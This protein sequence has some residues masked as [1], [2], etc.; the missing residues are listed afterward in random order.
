MFKFLRKFKKPI[1]VAALDRV[2]ISDLTKLDCRVSFKGE[3]VDLT[4]YNVTDIVADR[5]RALLDG[6]T[7]VKLSVEPVNDVILDAGRVLHPGENILYVTASDFNKEVADYVTE[8]KLYG[9]GYWCDGDIYHPSKNAVGSK[10]AITRSINTIREDQ[11]M[12]SVACDIA[13]MADKHSKSFEELKKLIAKYQY[14]VPVV[15]HIRVNHGC[16][17]S[18]GDFFITPELV[19]GYM[20]AVR[21]VLDNESFGRLREKVIEKFRIASNGNPEAVDYNK[22][23]VA[24]PAPESWQH[25]YYNSIKPE[26]ERRE[27]NRDIIEEIRGTIAEH[28]RMTELGHKRLVQR[29]SSLLDG[30]LAK[31]FPEDVKHITQG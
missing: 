28:E 10:L 21:P 26:E 1:E 5:L 16:N 31:A 6:K 19:D 22:P 23:T 29:L 25:L 18:I 24:V 3:I 13:H 14:L 20:T 9:D 8:N 4:M 30:E 17:W 27:R 12:Y 7:D 15:D 2:P 11:S